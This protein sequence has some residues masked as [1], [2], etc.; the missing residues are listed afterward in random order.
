MIGVVAALIAVALIIWLGGVVMT[1]VFFQAL[2]R[3]GLPVPEPEIRVGCG[4]HIH[5][6]FRGLLVAFRLCGTL[7]GLPRC[8]RWFI[9][10]VRSVPRLRSQKPGC[11]RG[12][13]DA[14]HVGGHS[15]CV[16]GGSGVCNK[17]GPTSGCARDYYRTPWDGAFPNEGQQRCRT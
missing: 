8:R 3:H 1:F 5:L 17:F 14:P 12:S 6:T 13:R 11:L 16:L 4:P 10:S 7:S 15:R 9:G 2:K